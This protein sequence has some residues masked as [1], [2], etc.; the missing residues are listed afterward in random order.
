[1]LLV[2][3]GRVTRVRRERRRILVCA[4]SHVCVSSRGYDC[5]GWT[6]VHRSRR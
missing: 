6:D 4:A 1:M 2:H 3:L 5:R